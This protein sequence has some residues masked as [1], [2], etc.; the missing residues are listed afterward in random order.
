MPC[1]RC[2]I[3]A[4]SGAH[5]KGAW[6][7]YHRSLGDNTFARTCAFFAPFMEHLLRESIFETVLEAGETDRWQ[8][9]PALLGIRESRKKVQPLTVPTRAQFSL[10]LHGC[11][12]DGDHDAAN[13]SKHL[14]R[15][16]RQL[17]ICTG[18]EASRERRRSP[19]VHITRPAHSESTQPAIYQNK[20]TRF[21]L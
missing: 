13:Q 15:A 4:A 16:R 1:T 2:G 14:Q 6:L 19:R 17:S 10:L 9:L 8:T 5:T 3:A 21:T 7:D 11:S 18:A 12:C 20:M